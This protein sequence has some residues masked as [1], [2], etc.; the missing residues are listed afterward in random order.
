MFST[1]GP[2]ASVHCLYPVQRLRALRNWLQQNL[3]LG[4]T[5]LR[6]PCSSF[7]TSTGAT[8]LPNVSHSGVT[9]TWHTRDQRQP[10]RDTFWHSWPQTDTSRHTRDQRQTPCDTLMTKGRQRW[11]RWLTF[12]GCRWACR[13]W[14]LSCSL[15]EDPHPC[16]QKP[17]AL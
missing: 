10:D 16:S 13:G 15:S 11:A 9:Y 14:S 4:I 3:D 6:V 1:C 2:L 5:P 8:C 17:K 7:Q 12:P